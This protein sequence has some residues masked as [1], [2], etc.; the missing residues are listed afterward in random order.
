VAGYHLGSNYD[1]EKAYFRDGVQHYEEVVF[2]C[3]SITDVKSRSANN[4]RGIVVETALSNE[5]RQITNEKGE[6]I[7]TTREYRQPIVLE[8]REIQDTKSLKPEIV[9]RITL[10]KT[11]YKVGD[12]AVFT[13]TLA[14]LEDSVIEPDSIRAF[15]N[16]EIVELQKEDT[17]TYTFT[18]KP[19]IKEHQQLIVSVEKSGFPTDTTYLSIPLHRIS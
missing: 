13:V 1:D 5:N 8:N 6:L 7:T 10:D 15:Y 9:T 4:A 12:K 19:L 17:G 18:T 2:A 3:T 11:S 16:G 14:D